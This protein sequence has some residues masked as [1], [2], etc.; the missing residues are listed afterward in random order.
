MT[1]LLLQWGLPTWA[2]L[3]IA[4]LAHSTV[5]VGGGW[6]LGR[7]GVVTGAR[8]RNLMWRLTLLAPL[9]TAPVQ[10]IAGPTW[11]IHYVQPAPAPLSPPVFEPA[12]PDLAP[13]DPA[14]VELAPVAEVPAQEAG[15]AIPW[16]LALAAFIVLARGGLL[17]YRVRRFRRTLTGRRPVT[18]LRVLAVLARLRRRSAGPSDL[19]LTV[20]D[21]LDGPV[22]LWGNEICLPPR[23]LAA[24]DDRALEAVLAHELAHL[25]R[26]DNLWLAIAAAVETILFI[27]P[28]NRVARRLLL[29]SAE[30]ASDERAVELTGDSLALARSLAEV[31]GW[32][33]ASPGN[34]LASAV[35]S[36]P[37]ALVQRVRSLL[38]AGDRPRPR[39]RRAGLF[40]CAGLGALVSLAPGVTFESVAAPPLPAAPAPATPAPATPAAQPKPDPAPEPKPQL[41]EPKPQPTVRPQPKPQ[42]T[43]KPQPKPQPTA[44]PAP[45]P[46]PAPVGPAATDTRGTWWMQ[47][48]DPGRLE[49]QFRNGRTSLRPAPTE[50]TGLSPDGPVRFALKREA[51][52]FQLDGSFRGGQG[53]GHFDFTLDPAFAAALRKR[54][55]EAPS[56]RQQI[57]LA[58]ADVGPVFLDELDR[59]GYQR[60]NLDQLVRLAEHG[61]RLDYLRGLTSLGYKF[62]SVDRLIKLRD[63]GV[64]VEFIRGLDALGY[65]QIPAE[66]L[67]RVRDHGVSTKFI[68]EVRALGHR[69]VPLAELIETLDHGVSAEYLRGLNASGLSLSLAEARRARDHG[70]S[71]EF[72]KA[73][74]PLGFPKL[75]LDQAIRVRDH[76]VS[77]EFLNALAQL[78]FPKLSLDEAI[79]IRDHGVSPEYIK[80]L[81]TLG[82]RLSV[83]QLIEARNHGV[84]PDYVRGLSQ[85]GYSKL[86][87]ASLIRLR[88]H[89]VNPEF[90]KR[91]AARGIKNPS[92]DTLIKLRNSGID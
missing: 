44:Q 29:E 43:A 61:V 86:E 33:L 28:L 47:L 58:L 8:A 21:A 59:L 22:A 78:G 6:L 54:G 19:S 81:E 73:L 91:M 38:E 53:A 75:S 50:L 87:M 62:D 80:Q 66:E 26:R 37:G 3:V 49:L 46:R 77:P 56:P 12:A 69:Q 18:D 4:Y 39:S 88:N 1:D 76:G 55:L 68:E 89:G 92:V 11:T 5:W 35:V 34:G 41:S 25:E 65:R 57:S 31:A 45:A 30:L 15:S 7:A 32:G 27:Q 48:D 10:L 2:V 13:V 83:S 84:S 70:V 67:I 40:A 64:T 51:G 14:P 9:V 90:V 52:T 72:L 17:A 79:R 24:L 74:V 85:V 42:P 71:P 63:H 60:P 16:V 23:A 36:T 82:Y 20:A